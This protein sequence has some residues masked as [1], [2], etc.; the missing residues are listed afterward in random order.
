[1]L[2]RKCRYTQKNG[3]RVRCLDDEDNVNVLSLF[4]GNP[5]IRREYTISLRQNLHNAKLVVICNLKISCIIKSHTFLESCLWTEG[6][7]AQ[8]KPARLRFCLRQSEPA[9][10]TET[11]RDILRHTET[12]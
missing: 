1:M 6:H 12:Y 9:G 4:Q 8:D 3:I 7:V 5:N 2:C 10:H 11:Y